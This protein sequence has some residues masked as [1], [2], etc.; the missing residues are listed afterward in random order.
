M[1]EQSAKIDKLLGKNKNMSKKL[2]VIKEQNQEITQQNEELIDKVTIVA[3]DRVVKTQTSDDRHMFV[4]MKDEEAPE[5][6][7]YYAIRTK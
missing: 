4:V 1:K 5:K 3:E 6:E 7:R 2:T